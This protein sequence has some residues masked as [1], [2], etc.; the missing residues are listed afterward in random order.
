MSSSAFQL[1]IVNRL[2][3]LPLVNS[4]LDVANSSYARIKSY[5]PLVTATLD[6]AEKSLTFVASSAM[7]VLSG[8]QQPSK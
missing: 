8:L 1:N 2:Q 3:T 6:R 4:A 5:S 7:P